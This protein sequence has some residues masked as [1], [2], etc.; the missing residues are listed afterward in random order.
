MPV[1]WQ[2]LSAARINAVVQNFGVDPRLM[3]QQLTFLNRTPIVPAADGEIMARV[4]GYPTI[5]DI[6]ADDQQA[7]TYQ[8]TKIQYDTTTIPNIKH[9]APM[10]QAMLAELTAIEANG[11]GLPAGS[12]F[13][14]YESMVLANLVLGV[15]QRMEALLVAMACDGLTYDR[16]GIKLTGV[17]WGMPS[18]LKVT[19]GTAWDNAGSATPVA[20]MLAVKLIGS[21]RYGI[22]Y[23]RVTM[24]TQ[25]F[26]YMV[27][28]TEFQNK[29]RQ[30][31]APNV[32][33]TNLNIADLPAQKMIAQNVLGMAIEL[34]DARYFQQ[35]ADGTLSSTPFLPITKVILSSTA[36]DGN[37]MV[38]DFANGV[39]V[40]SQ[41]ASLLGGSLSGLGGPQRGP[42]GY[43]TADE[44]LNPPQITYW[45][46]AR[47]FPRKKLFQ[48][49]AVL[50]VGTFSDAISA[51]VPF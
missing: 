24:S 25:A 45:A 33:Y 9:G 32:S 28:T 37:A 21:V 1:A 30:Y 2:L 15:R 40:E 11:G 7:V 10:T 23:D 44:G 48:A 12:M 4:T 18:D 49:N 19:T 6:I 20:D 14:Q 47:G 29:A 35:A 31:L 27:A 50:T 41:V 43:A 46:V 38:Q 16:L 51:T 34:Y 42:V 17:T 5:A 39:V 22:N 13:A 36:S 3:P 8:N 26:R